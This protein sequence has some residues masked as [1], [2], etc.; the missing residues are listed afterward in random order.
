MYQ[1]PEGSMLHVL[2]VCLFT[3][4]LLSH[5]LF[6]TLRHALAF[7]PANHMQFSLSI[8]DQLCD[9]RWSHLLGKNVKV[10]SPLSLQ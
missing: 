1:C 4:C 2:F 8:L 7:V 5:G 6:S 3:L 10:H 9:L